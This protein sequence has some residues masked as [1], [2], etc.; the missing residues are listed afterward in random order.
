MG[1]VTVFGLPADLPIWVDARVMDARADRP[2]RRLAVVEGH[3]DAGDP[4]GAAR[5]GGRRG[6]RDG[7]PTRRPVG[8]RPRRAGRRLDRRRSRPVGPTVRRPSGRPTCPYPLPARRPTRPQP[9]A[10][11]RRRPTCRPDA[12]PTPPRPPRADRDPIQYKGDDLEA[13]R[14]PGLGCFRF[15]VVVLAIFIVLTPLS[16]VWDWPDR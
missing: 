6:A 10:G 13:E 8:R 11:S 9:R 5:D 2:R 12:D 1:G 3:L 4:A 14:G 7:T 16:V 15:Q